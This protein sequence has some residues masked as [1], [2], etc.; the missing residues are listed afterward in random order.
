MGTR[1]RIGIQNEDGTITSVY[2][3]WDGYPDWLGKKLCSGY[4]SEEKIRELM[5]K[6]DISS[7]ESKRDWDRKELEVPIVLYYNDRGEKTEKQISSSLLSYFSLT[8][9]CGGE[10][11]YLYKNGKWECYNSHGESINL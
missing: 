7:L 4:K 1:S 6:G 10:Y 2:H 3:H 11:C 8:N 9:D 5:V